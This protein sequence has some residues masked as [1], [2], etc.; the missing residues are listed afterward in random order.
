MVSMPFMASN[1]AHGRSPSASANQSLRSRN[2]SYAHV[3]HQ[4][5]SDG[6]GRNSAASKYSPRSE[7]AHA[8]WGDRR[9]QNTYS[10]DHRRMHAPS[11]DPR[12]RYVAA[13]VPSASSSRD[14]AASDGLT[15]ND[16]Y[17]SS[18]PATNDF[19]EEDLANVFS[20]AR[21][22]RSKDLERVLDSSGIPPNVRDQHGNTILIIACQNGLKRIAK[23]ALRRGADINARNYKGNTCLHFCFA[24]GYGDTLGKYLISK[25]ADSSIRNAAGLSCY[26]GL[27][28][29][30]K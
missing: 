2:S 15:F 7:D 22:N 27:T 26:E 24:Y 20:F 28:H 6:S 25:G 16:G 19:D 23:V 21:H 29:P 13:E 14:V 1:D 17:H 30:S 8:N 3:D 11:S 9:Q 18:Y 12:S 5:Y 10:K 4:R